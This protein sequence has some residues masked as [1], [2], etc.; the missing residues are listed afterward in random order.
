MLAADSAPTATM[1]KRALTTSP[2][3]VRTVQS[4]V[5]SSKTTSTT[6]LPN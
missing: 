6:R 1:T 3:S 2:L 5:L 4:S